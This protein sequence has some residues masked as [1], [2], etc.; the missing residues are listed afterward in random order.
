MLSQDSTYA[1]YIVFKTYRDGGLDYPPQEASIT[2]S[3]G[4]KSTRKVCLQRRGNEQEDGRASE[5]RYD[6]SHRHGNLASFPIK[7]TDDG[8]M[9]LEMGQ[10]Y[11]K[12]GDD[13]EVGI[14]LM[15]TEKGHVK[16]GLIVLGIE[17]R[18]KRGFNQHACAKIGGQ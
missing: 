10:F 3:A 2:S 8:W 7:R 12:D 5:P 16:T 1:A 9:E 15:E 4:S 17:I 14:C 11:N 18:P 6:R 13:G